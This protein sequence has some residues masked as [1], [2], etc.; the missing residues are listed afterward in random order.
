VIKFEVF[1]FT[2]YKDKKSDAK[3]RKWGGLV[4][5]PALSDSAFR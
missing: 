1:S 2:Y 4:Q 3:R 5:A